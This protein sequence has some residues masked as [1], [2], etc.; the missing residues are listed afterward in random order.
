M[1]SGNARINIFDTFIGRHSLS[2]GRVSS[3]PL[4]LYE[5]LPTIPAGRSAVRLN[6]PIGNTSDPVAVAFAEVL[7]PVCATQFV[8]TLRTREQIR[9][10]VRSSPQIIRTQIYATFVVQTEKLSASAALARIEHWIQ[11]SVINGLDELGEYLE[12]D[13]DKNTTAPF[14][15]QYDR[16][17]LGVV[18]QWYPSLEAKTEQ[19]EKV[20]LYVIGI[21]LPYAIKFWQPA[22]MTRED[23]R[24]LIKTYFGRKAA[25]RAIVL[26]GANLSGLWYTKC[27]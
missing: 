17:K 25:W 4:F 26:E 11:S 7:K 12:F 23:F 6:V 3:Q 22:G 14:K 20:S 19:Q 18:T 10:T 2:I 21:I 8:T 16:I 15:A 5:S 24:T 9:Y 27:S 1:Y 13:G